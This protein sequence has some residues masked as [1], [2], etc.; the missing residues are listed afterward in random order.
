MKALLS[1]LVLASLVGFG[2]SS[3][4][5][6]IGSATCPPNTTLK[7]ADFGKPFV[8]KYCAQCHGGGQSQGGISLEGVGNV[9]KNKAAMYKEAAADNTSMPPSGS[10]KPTADERK[11]LGDWLACGAN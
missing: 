5:S 4:G 2:C 8:D 3:S 7:Y 10:T 6:D 11:Q 9:Q 1:A